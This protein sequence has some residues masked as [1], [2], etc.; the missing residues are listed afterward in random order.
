[1]ELPRF[2]VLIPVFNHGLTVRDVARGARSRYEVL[3]VDDGSTDCTGAVL[4]QEPDLRVLTLPRNEGKAA[5]LLHGFQLAR[6]QGFTHAITMDA[7]GQHPVD[8]LGTFAELACRFPDAFII[9]VRDLRAEGA[10]VVRRFSNALSN[11]FFW[12]ETGLGLADTQCG[13]RVYPLERVMDLPV[14]ASRYAYELEVMVRAA[15][16]A[17]PLLPCP[18][19]ADY[20]APTSRLSH[21]HPL[22][23]FSHVARTHLRL[24]GEMLLRRLTRKHGL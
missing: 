23:D 3:V 21:F 10:P 1:M 8:A 5:A 15:W 4:A 18:V 13:F 2:C 19:K 16:A 9:G 7:D 6:D 14:R 24:T 22:F 17:I 20:A 12:I 11:L